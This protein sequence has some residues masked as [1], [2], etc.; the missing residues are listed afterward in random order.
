MYMCLCVCVLGSTLCLVVF[1]LRSSSQPRLRIQSATKRLNKKKLGFGAFP[2]SAPKF[3]NALPQTI[4]EADSSATF[5]RRL[6]A[7]L[8]SVWLFLFS[9][10]WTHSAPK[11]FCLPKTVSVH[12]LSIISFSTLS[13]QVNGTMRYRS[14]HH[15]HHLHMPHTGIS[16]S[17]Y[18]TKWPMKNRTL[19]GLP[20]CKHILYSLWT[21]SSASTPNWRKIGIWETCSETQCGHQNGLTPVAG[22]QIPTWMCKSRITTP[23]YLKVHE[24]LTVNLRQQTP[25]HPKAV[26][27]GKDTYQQ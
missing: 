9:S 3:W 10:C 18:H 27:S 6:K 22:W 4:R 17:H 26:H 8:F 19:S 7:H 11:L 21:S 1:D 15:H 25:L 24:N 5:C 14:G 2:N 12:F 16:A 23:V 20:W 13:I